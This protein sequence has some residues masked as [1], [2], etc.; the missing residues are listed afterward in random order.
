MVVSSL[1]VAPDIVF[2][3]T[4]FDLN[5]DIHN[6]TYH[7]ASLQAIDSFAVENLGGCVQVFDSNDTV[8]CYSYSVHTCSGVACPLECNPQEDAGALNGNHKLTNG[9]DLP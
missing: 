3:I 7:E 4:I 2:L 8:D 6:H 9:N 1:L 5:M